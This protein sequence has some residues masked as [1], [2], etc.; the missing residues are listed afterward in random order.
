MQINS[1]LLTLML[2]E[3]KTSLLSAY[4]PSDQRGIRFYDSG[5]ILLGRLGYTDIQPIPGSEIRY[6]FQSNGDWV[7]KSAVIT[8][9]AVS[10]FKIAG[11]Y[12]NGTTHEIIDD[13]IKGSAGPV[14]SDIRFNNGVWTVSSIMTLS[15]LSFYIK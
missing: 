10:N 11:D 12:Y 15:S 6:G 2:D 9:G 8:G 7:L 1:N 4:I 13:I 3:V 5:D 14:G